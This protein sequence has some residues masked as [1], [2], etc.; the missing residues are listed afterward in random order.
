LLSRAAVAIEPFCQD[1]QR[2][3]R[4]VGHLQI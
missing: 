1:R 2:A 3:L 4:S